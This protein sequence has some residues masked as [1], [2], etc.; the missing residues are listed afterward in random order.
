MSRAVSG[1]RKRT[2]QFKA[3]QDIEKKREAAHRRVDELADTLAELTQL[4]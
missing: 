2:L 4:E 3:L 1:G